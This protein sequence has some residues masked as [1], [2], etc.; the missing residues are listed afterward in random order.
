MTASSAAADDEVAAPAYDPRRVVSLEQLQIL[1][2][3]VDPMWIFDSV[4]RKM[5]WANDAG[6][7]LWNSSSL[8]ELLARDFTDMSTATAMRLDETLMRCQLGQHVVDQWTYYPK[9]QAKTV[10]VNLSGVRIEGDRAATSTSTPN[11][12]SNLP[13]MCL[14]NEGVPVVQEELDNEVLRG[15]EMLRHLP[16]SIC[17]FDMD[18]KTMF[19]N[20]EAC[21]LEDESSQGAAAEE[22]EKVELEAA[23]KEE[24]HSVSAAADKEGTMDASKDAN[25]CSGEAAQK[26]RNDSAQEGK[27]VQKPP[28]EKNNED[29]ATSARRKRRSSTPV[30]NTTNSLHEGNKH[31]NHQHHKLPPKKKKAAGDLVHR[32]VDTKIGQQVLHQIQTSETPL[33]LEAML[34]SQKGQTWSH[35]QLRQSKDPV[36]GERVILYSAQDKSD[37]VKFRKEREARKQ[38]SEF[39]AIMA[40]EIRTPLH[41][42]TGF[43][44]LLDQT[45]LTKEQKSFVRLLKSSAQG[46]MTVINDVLDYSKLEAGKMKLENIPYEPLSVTKGS[47]EAVRASSEE[48]KLYLK[49]EWDK[50]IP[51]KLKADPNRLRQ[52]GTG[53]VGAQQCLCRICT[54]VGLG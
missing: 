25:D 45:E 20:P 9:G 34:H 51:F 23:N 48:R 36:T 28:N 14:L 16:I 13:Y 22:E 35:V 2:L 4:E 46:L 12:D 40:H 3:I 32:F 49:L 24:G 5:R 1:N 19:Q 52:V 54:N 39:L 44:D 37:A 27:Q 31:D 53:H 18:G 43:V 41:Q 29:K 33:D 38:K 11:D 6:V 15:V 21:L 7:E 30:T 42:V 50:T 8:D 26:N 10:H 47:M 17:Q